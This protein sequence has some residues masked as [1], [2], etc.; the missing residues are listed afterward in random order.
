MRK[1][2]WLMLVAVVVATTVMAVVGA[3]VYML[4]YSLA[5]D[6]N[7]RDVDSCYQQ[8]LAEYPECGEWMDSLRGINA[9]RDTFVVM[10]TGERHHALYI[11]KG[12]GKTA[13]VLHGWRDCA[14]KFLWLARIYE[15]ALGYN[16]VMPELH[17]CGE[18]EGDV[19]Q[20]GWK[21]RR[22]VMEWMKVFRA[23]TMVV[24]GVSMGAAT[25][26]MLSGETMP[27]GIKDLRF[28]ADC[29]YT[30][31]WD[32][33]AMQLKAQFGLPAFPLMYTTSLLCRLRYGW[34]FDEAS[35]I[36]QVRKCRY[37]MLF[38]H[39]DNDSFVPTRMVYPLYAAK[40]GAKQLWISK[41]AEHA[42]AY[43][44]HKE[45]YIRQLRQ[46][47]LVSCAQRQEVRVEEG[48][49]RPAP[50][51]GEIVL[52]K[53]AYTVSYNQETRC[54]N[55]VAWK[56]TAEHTD[57]PYKR[58]NFYEEDDVPEPRATLRDYKGSGWSR[59]HMCPAG[60]NKWDSEAMAESFS[61][62]NVCPQNARLNSG[63][64]NS[65]EMDCRKWARK[66]G[67]VYVVCGPVYLNKAHE[68]IGP[69]EVVVPEAFFK[70][71]LCLKGK[72]KAIG[73]VVKNT[74]GAK[75]KDLY[76]NTIDQVERIT[77]YDFFPSLPDDIEKKVEARANIRE[78]R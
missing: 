13:V 14:I 11:D 8:L 77:G 68:A 61:L 17:A 10:A 60:D 37:P 18:S 22:D 20:M 24:H 72:P 16:V 3:S 67:E 9:L 29:G 53:K 31:V 71:V 65:I 49:E 30:S 78:W 5:P 45:E 2:K 33:F 76:Y 73:V 51:E 56:L 75:K 35:A 46:F 41:G 74:E 70:V 19:I 54:P 69:N 55:W 63:V 23:D 21:D 34:R 1:R 7:R 25:T 64:W 57:G 38:I 44:A 27:E 58:V 32:E 42:Q 48:V 39:G 36:A 28:V 40:V 52:E 12:V 66:Y 62:V 15:R 59:G 47:S 26:M 4:D 50:I 6:P 43:Q